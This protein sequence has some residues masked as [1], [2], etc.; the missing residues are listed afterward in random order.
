MRITS[1]SLQGL[2]GEELVRQGLADLR[3]G[4]RTAAACLIAIA[5]SRLAEAGLVAPEDG[6]LISE[7]ELQLYRLLRAE[8]DGSDAYSRYGA[9]TREL[10]SFA[11]ALEKRSLRRRGLGVNS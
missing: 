10:G 2:P 11:Q 8:N 5:R 9:L 7:P 1:E 3:S 4:K 6:S